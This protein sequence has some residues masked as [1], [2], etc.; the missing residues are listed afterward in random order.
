MRALSDRLGINCSEAPDSLLK[1]AGGDSRRIRVSGW[2][3]AEV[4]DRY[5]ADSG[6]ER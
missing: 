4:F 1:S 3:L 5:I 6:K 2:K